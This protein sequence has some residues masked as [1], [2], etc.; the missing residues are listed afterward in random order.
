[1]NEKFLDEPVCMT[2]SIGGF[3]IEEVAEKN[4]DAIAKFPIDIVH[5]LDMAGAK[6]IVTAVGIDAKKVDELNQSLLNLYELFLTKDISMV[7]INPFAKDS[8]GG[9]VCLDAKLK[10][11]DKAEFR[12]E[13][14]FDQ[15]D[16]SQ[17]DKRELH[18]K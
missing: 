7:Q 15:R 1:M 4:P 17:E 14:V 18:A 13:A 16:W 9:F 12:Q 8:N 11:D 2:S 3:I 6:E 10:F 5:G